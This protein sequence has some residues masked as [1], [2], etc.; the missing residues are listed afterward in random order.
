MKHRNMLNIATMLMLLVILF[1]TGCS[2]PKNTPTLPPAAP[3]ATVDTLTGTISS[4][5]AFALYPMMTVWRT[6]SKK[7]TRE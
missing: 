2:T 3:T 5:G 7:S 4:S 1:T 6:N